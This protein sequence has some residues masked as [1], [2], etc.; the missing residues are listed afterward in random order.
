MKLTATKLRKIK[1]TGK[2]QNLSDSGGLYLVVSAKGVCSWRYKYRLHGKEQTLPLG[3][4]P[5]IE[6]VQARD[7]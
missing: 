5:Q 2:T 1:P 7:L 4:Y 3:K 6:L